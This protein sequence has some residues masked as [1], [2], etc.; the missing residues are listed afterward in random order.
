MDPAD[1][2]AL[3]RAL[4]DGFRIGAATSAFQI[5]GAADEDGKGP[6]SWDV[7]T[8]EPGRVVDDTDARVSTDHYHRF[9]ED[10]ALL[11]DLGVDSYRFSIAWTRIQPTGSGPVEP[12]GLAFYDRL[13]D[14][15]L[16]AGIRPSATL[17]HWDTPAALEEKGGWRHRDTALRFADYARIA[18]EQFGDRVDEW[19]TI[20]EVNTITLEGYGIGMHAPGLKLFARSVPVA[21]NLL[22]GHG[23]AVQQL[24]AVPVTG[25][26]GIAGVHSTVEPAS[27]TRRDRLAAE[28]FDFLDN[29]V[30]VDPVLLGRVP[31][32]P[33]GAGVL[34]LVLR[35]LARP[36]RGDLA[37]IA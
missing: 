33:H 1:P 26:V 11:R 6:S 18:G 5:E 23:L 3:A 10:V 4:P 7:F 34:G 19:V 8:R 27:G 16:E 37:V 9:R 30:F 28:V 2:S 32:A 12:R 15:L 31:K 29:R 17:F 14:E 24:R 13:I 20:N 36:R 21:Y 22:L 35:V 25:R